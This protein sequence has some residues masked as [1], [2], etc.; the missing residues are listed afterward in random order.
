MAVG[1]I[2]TWGVNASS[3]SINVDVVGVVLMI[4]MR[5]LSPGTSCPAYRGCE[6]LRFYPALL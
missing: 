3:S 1:A 6:R 5:L 4:P 2:L